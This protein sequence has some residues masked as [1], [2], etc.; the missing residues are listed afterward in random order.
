MCERGVWYLMGVIVCRVC[1]QH[2]DPATFN[3]VSTGVCSDCQKN[4]EKIDGR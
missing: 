3:E 4:S 2:V 1:K